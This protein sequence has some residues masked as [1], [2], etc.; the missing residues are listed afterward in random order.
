MN[1]NGVQNRLRKENKRAQLEDD[2]GQALKVHVQSHAQ[3]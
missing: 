1:A 3:N 2:H